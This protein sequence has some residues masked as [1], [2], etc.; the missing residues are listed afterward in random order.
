[1]PVHG[2]SLSYLPPN[3]AAMVPQGTMGAQMVG[4]PPAPPGGAAITSVGGGG[5]V[6][7]DI[8]A[9][10]ANARAAATGAGAPGAPELS[11]HRAFPAAPGA[12]VGQP[13]MGN[14]P[15]FRAY[16][17]E[18]IAN[19]LSMLLTNPN[20]A[21]QLDR[22]LGGGFGQLLSRWGL[23]PEQIQAEGFD[24]N[25]L[26]TRQDARQ[27]WRAGNEVQAPG[28]IQT[29]PAT[30]QPAG[31]AQ[32]VDPVAAAAASG[33]GSGGTAAPAPTQQVAPAQ[34]FQ[35]P[36]KPVGA[37]K[38]TGGFNFPGLQNQ[39]PLSVGNNPFQAFGNI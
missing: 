17:P 39:G 20:L 19:V 31:P 6:P 22:I 1:M 25:S 2:D 38:G 9:M 3:I 29:A 24:P 27:D 21:G 23:T 36:A 28:Y 16:M 35:R 30:T 34:G 15:D 4:A 12:T 8:A 14:R 11:S 5:A 13:G 10:I 32:P 37:N 7:P 26:Y 18:G 33:L